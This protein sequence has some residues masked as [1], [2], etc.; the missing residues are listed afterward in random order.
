MV[1]PQSRSD[2]L[3]GGALR[4]VT[5]E[6]DNDSASFHCIWSWHVLAPPSIIVMEYPTVPLPSVYARLPIDLIVEDLI[7]KPILGSCVAV[8]T[9]VRLA[10][11]R[12]SVVGGT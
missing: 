8:N 5:A 1:F 6:S 7:I 2:F 10:D 9:K 4:K 12:P 3:C 11:A